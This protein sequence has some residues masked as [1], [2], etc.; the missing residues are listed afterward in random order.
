MAGSIFSASRRAFFLRRWGSRIFCA[1]SRVDGS[2]PDVP[3][4]TNCTLTHWK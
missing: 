2:L 1:G 4:R 3:Q